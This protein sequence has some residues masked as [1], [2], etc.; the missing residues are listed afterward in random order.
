MHPFIIVKVLVILT[1]DQWSGW[2]ANVFATI[3][4][5]LQPYRGAVLKIKG[6][7]KMHENHSE[8]NEMD[9]KSIVCASLSHI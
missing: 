8:L 1:Y 9:A 4:T 5:R 7:Y 2:F 6:H 3:L